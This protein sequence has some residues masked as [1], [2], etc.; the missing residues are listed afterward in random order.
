[1]PTLIRLLVF[2]LVLAGLAFG[3]MV[4]LTL[5][6]DPGQKEIRRPIPTRDLMPGQQQ[7]DPLGIREQLPEPVLETPA[8]GAPATESTE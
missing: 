3:G 2:L 8:E 5:F 4:A 7:N 6:V 1:M